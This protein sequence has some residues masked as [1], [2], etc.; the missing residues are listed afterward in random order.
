MTL[1]LWLLAAEAGWRGQGGAGEFVWLAEWDIP[2][3][4]VKYPCFPSFYLTKTFLLVYN[5]NATCNHKLTI[6]T[7]IQTHTQTLIY[8]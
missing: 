5:S 2:G 1:L 3:P 6:Q 7:Y 8:N 4:S